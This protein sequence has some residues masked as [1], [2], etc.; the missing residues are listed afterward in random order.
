MRLPLTIFGEVAA[1]ASLQRRASGR[2]RV[3]FCFG[4]ERHFVSLKTKDGREAERSRVRVEENLRDLERGRLEL[5]PGADLGVFLL[6]GG[7]LSAKPSYQKPVTLSELFQTYREQFPSG[8]KEANTRVTEE[9]HIRHLLRI[10]GEDQ[11]VAAITPQVMQHYVAERSKDKGAGG[12]PLSHT[13]VA[14]EVGTFASV[15]NRFAWPKGIV[16]SSAPTKG[17]VYNKKKA[18]PPFQTRAQVERQIGRGGLS[19]V[20]IDELWDSV[21]LTLAE[22]EQLLAYIQASVRQKQIQIL[23]FLAA[24]SGM[25]RSEMLRAQVN[26]FDFDTN[27]VLV[28]EK[29][30]DR[31]REMTFRSVPMSPF[32]KEMLQKWFG[33]H[34]GGQF[35]VCSGLAKPLSVQ[36]AAHAF[37]RA[38]AGSAW[39]NLPGW[40]CLRHSFASNCAL[41]GIDPRIV[42]RWMGHQTDQMRQRY[43]HL[44][45]DQQQDAMARVFGSFIGSSAHSA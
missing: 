2:F 38:V 13:T 32:L 43:L 34:P 8:A 12:K 5:P 9:I 15:W 42:D 37:R 17:L 44:F 36:A 24:H 3:I 22:V 6:S 40:H 7:K 28:R 35:A 21:F 25:R 41:K 39:E 16:S 19:P 45:P 20:Q 29:K 4:G 33:G 1:M 23:F 30:K 10:L 31:S 14:K 27:M 26:D 11:A 18:K